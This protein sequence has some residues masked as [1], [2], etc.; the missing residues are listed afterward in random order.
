MDTVQNSEKGKALR[1]RF[2]TRK[3]L[4]ICI[5]TA[6]FSSPQRQGKTCNSNFFDYYSFIGNLSKAVFTNIS[7]L[8]ETSFK[9]QT[10]YIPMQ[11]VLSTNRTVP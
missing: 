1:W 4:R 11:S 7:P 9:P 8:V 6:P 2:G 10:E 3:H 5:K